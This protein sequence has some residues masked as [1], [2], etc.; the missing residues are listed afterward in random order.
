MPSVISEGGVQ[1][2]SAP[3]AWKARVKIQARVEQRIPEIRQLE[4]NPFDVRWRNILSILLL[5]TIIY[6]SSIVFSF[7]MFV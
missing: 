1:G 7:S 4:T 6:F 5:L 3:Q 2:V